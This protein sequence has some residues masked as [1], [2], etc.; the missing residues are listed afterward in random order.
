MEY[1]STKELIDEVAKRHGI[2][3]DDKDP[4][5][6]TLT[7]NELII[8][9]Y[10]KAIEASVSKINARQ[11]EN[12]KLV[13]E[14]IISKG[15]KFLIQFIPNQYDQKS[16]VSTKDHQVSNLKYLL[17]SHLWILCSAYLFGMF[18]FWIFEQIAR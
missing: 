17:I 15:A 4:I 3:L 11:I 12:A 9:N 14:D 16:L 18:S 2:I 8:E 6:V 5:L 13:G 10:V 1:I 7:L